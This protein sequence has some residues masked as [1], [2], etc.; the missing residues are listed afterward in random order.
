MEILRSGRTALALIGLSTAAL[1][2]CSIESYHNDASDVH[3][4]GERTIANLGD[5]GMASFIV[6]GERDGEVATVKV[7]RIDDEVSVSVS[8]EPT[9]PPQLVEE[10]GFTTPTPIVEGPELNAFAAGGAWII[11]VRESSAVIQGSCD[12]L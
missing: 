10:D 7:R 3:C 8:G 4:N 9:G 1:A 11:D 12:G 6:H 5:S 2:G